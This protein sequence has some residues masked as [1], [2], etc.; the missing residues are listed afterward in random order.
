MTAIASVI[1]PAHDEAGCIGGCLAALLESGPLPAGWRGEVI[2]VAN[3]CRDDTAA[4]AGGFAG[5]AASRGWDLQ[6]IEEVR[7]GKLRALN[8]GDGAA[9]ESEDPA[10]PAP[11]STSSS[12]SPPQSPQWLRSPGSRSGSATGTTALSW[13]CWS[14]AWC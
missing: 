10:S 6:V 11:A 3:G 13:R 9:R 4:I 2:V 8:R 14:A 5:M 7:G 1:L 12:G